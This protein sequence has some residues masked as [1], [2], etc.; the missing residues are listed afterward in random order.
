MLMG[1]ARTKMAPTA[2]SMDTLKYFALIPLLFALK[3]CGSGN[4][5]PASLFEIQLEG[6]RTEFKQ[7]ETVGISLKNKRGKTIDAVTYT[8]DGKELQV[9]DDKIT[10][11]LS[12]LGNKSLKA[13]VKFEENAVEVSKKI[14]VLAENSPVLYTYEIINEYPHDIKAYTQG[15]EFHND[16]LYES[17]GK[18]GAVLPTENCLPIGQGA[19]TNRFG[20]SIL[21]RG[22]YHYEQPNLPVNLAKQGRVY[23]WPGQ[24]YKNE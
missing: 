21:W 7:N 2:N 12:T 5:S 24:F 3:S 11:D 20:R 18:K 1:A 13:Q 10:L 4:T 23:I 15:L 17:T 19:R 22:T 8:I 14:K 9:N 16:T 6:K